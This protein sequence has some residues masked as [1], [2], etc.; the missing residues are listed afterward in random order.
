MIDLY[1]LPAN[2]PDWPLH[3]VEQRFN[4]AYHG[5]F[6]RWQSA[7]ASLPTHTTTGHAYTDIVSAQLN[8]DPTT[9]ADIEDA[10]QQLHP[11]RKGPF[12]IGSVH[13]DTEWRSD[14]K[15]QRLKPALGDLSNQRVLDIG[16]GNGYFGWRALAAGA[17]E[18]IGVDPTILF[19]MQHQAVQRFMQDPRNWVLP[20]KIEE[21]PNTVQFDLTLS[22]GV[23]YHRRDP[24]QHVSQLYDLTAPGGRGVLETLVVR[25][26]SSLYPSERYA[27]MRNVW[28]VPSTD[29]LL[30]WMQQAG[31]QDVNVIDISTT[32]IEEQ[33]STPWM[34]FESLVDCLNPQDPTRTIEGHPAPVRMM[35]QGHKPE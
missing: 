27:R 23:L 29:Q 20:L 1:A 35:C 32:T 9:Q 2:L 30:E 15:W 25:D 24:L 33:H 34:R 21:L 19:C 3:L 10:L 13:I 4:A 8:C 5:D 18:V 28:C 31:F 11:W 14:W 17:Q 26:A 22:M 7:V 6:E 12:Q 16:C